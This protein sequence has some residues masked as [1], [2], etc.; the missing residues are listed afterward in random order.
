[1]TSISP[2]QPKKARLDRNGARLFLGIGIF[3][4]LQATILF[5]AAGTIRWTAAWAYFGVYLI[6]Y[7]VGLAW[8]AAVNP[9]VINERGRRSTNTEEFD[10]RFHR[11][12]PLLI[13]CML[14]VGGLDHR[15][16]WSTMP[17]ALPIIGLLALLPALFLAVWVLATNAFASR[18][19]RIQD[20]HQV[21]MTGPYRYVR[22][23]MYSGTL[24]AW[25]AAALALAS[26]WMFVPAAAGIALFVWR[27]HREDT[28]LLD[29]LPG[30]REYA[31]ETRFRLVPGLW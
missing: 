30:Y 29:K 23:P 9:A 2:S 28:A 17:A 20:G 13:L 18:V 21:I 24:L 1:M 4:A 15:F 11:V 19:V 7:A 5:T 3:V 8:V 14:V 22:H 27:T 25:I 10:Q 31:R 16:G 6:S 12:M 26:W